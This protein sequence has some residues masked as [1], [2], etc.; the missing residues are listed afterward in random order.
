MVMSSEHCR[1]YSSRLTSNFQSPT[2]IPADLYF[3]LE[4][5]IVFESRGPALMSRC[6]RIG[7]DSAC[8]TGTQPCGALY[9]ASLY[10]LMCLQANNIDGD[11]TVQMMHVLDIERY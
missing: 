1:P 3:H 8:D 2:Y 11:R 6:F 7:A 10:A 5:G 4:S 9:G